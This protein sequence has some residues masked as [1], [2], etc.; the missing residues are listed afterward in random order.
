MR[1]VPNPCVGG[2]RGGGDDRVQERRVLHVVREHVLLHLSEAVAGRL[3]ANKVGGSHGVESSGCRDPPRAPRPVR[4]PQLDNDEVIAARADNA[5]EHRDNLRVLVV[6]RRQEPLHSRAGRS[7]LGGHGGSSR[8]LA[9]VH[10][11][12]I[13]REGSKAL[14]HHVSHPPVVLLTR[15]ATGRNEAIVIVEL[16]HAFPRVPCAHPQPVGCVPC[17]Q[18]ARPPPE[19]LQLLAVHIPLPGFQRILERRQRLLS[20]TARLQ[21]VAY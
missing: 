13:Q 7:S 20:G 21:T 14:L 11:Q 8:A 12:G 2:G 17:L 1:C 10:R 6:E 19:S 3:D 9:E 5:P 15:K 4:R 18:L 16:S